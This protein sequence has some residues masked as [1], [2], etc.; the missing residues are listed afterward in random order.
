[1]GR[2]CQGIIHELLPTAAPL[3]VVA[4]E[5][6]ALAKPVNLETGDILLLGTDGIWEARNPLGEMFKTNRLRQLVATLAQKNARLIHDTIMAKVFDFMSGAQPMD[7]M[8]LMVIKVVNE[9]D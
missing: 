9:G 1:M 2:S 3:S 7:D 4:S 8:T 6:F 5:T